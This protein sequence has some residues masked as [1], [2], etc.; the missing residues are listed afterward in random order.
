MPSFPAINANCLMR[1]SR[2]YTANCWRVL[3]GRHL[4]TNFSKSACSQ[5]SMWR[6]RGKAAGDGLHYT[7]DDSSCIPSATPHAYGY[8]LRNFQDISHQDEMLF[9]EIWVVSYHTTV[10]ESQFLVWLSRSC[11]SDPS[12]QTNPRA[13]TLKLPDMECPHLP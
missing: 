8:G 9:L 3:H 12:F 6:R 2:I 13:T 11:R 10:P 1:A 5:R 7:E 4:S